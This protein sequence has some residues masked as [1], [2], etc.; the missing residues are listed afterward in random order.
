MHFTPRRIAGYVLPIAGYLA[1]RLLHNPNA[2]DHRPAAWLL[3]IGCFI[4]AILLLA[5]FKKEKSERSGIVLLYGFIAL[6]VA[7]YYGSIY[8]VF[9]AWMHGF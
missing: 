7:L 8:L 2:G 5:D 9:N 3:P 1:A 4:G 6:L